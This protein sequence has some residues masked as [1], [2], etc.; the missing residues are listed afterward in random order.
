MDE[1]L[2]K[3]EKIRKKKYDDTKKT[4][5]YLV[6]WY[7]YDTDESTW[8]PEENLCYMPEVVNKFNEKWEERKKL[9]KQKKEEQ[10][11]QLAT[12]R[13]LKLTRSKINSEIP[14]KIPF[15]NREVRFA[16]EQSEEEES[17]Q[18]EELK[19][20]S[21]KPSATEDESSP[22]FTSLRVAH[23]RIYY[24]DIIKIIGFREFKGK[25]YVAVLFKAK[26]NQIYSPGVF[27]LQIFKS[28]YSSVLKQYL[29]DNF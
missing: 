8:E 25:N 14:A 6:K 28:S 18:E 29:I 21:L 10:L 9:I 16:D 22:L 23:A 24:N 26:E 19:I 20:R 27:D 12:R 1:N 5:L 13:K 4:W 3:V 15:Q 17:S 7:G 11:T 2:Y